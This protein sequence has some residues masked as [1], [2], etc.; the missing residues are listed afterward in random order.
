TGAPTWDSIYYMTFD[1]SVQTWSTNIST[2]ANGANNNYWDISDS[3]IG[4]GTIGTCVNNTY[5]PPGG[6]N[7]CLYITSQSN[8]Y[9][10]PQYAG[11]RYDAGGLCDIFSF[12]TN[13]NLAA[14]SPGI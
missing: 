1:S 14:Q 8:P 12:C 2:G 13:T 11:A 9:G 10:L 6:S 5:A 4:N 7:K 3:C